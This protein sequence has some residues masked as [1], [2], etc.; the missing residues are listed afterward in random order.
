[1]IT[2]GWRISEVAGLEVQA[3][4]YSY[5]AHRVKNSQRFPKILSLSN[6]PSVACLCSSHRYDASGTSGS[7]P[8]SRRLA[9]T[10]SFR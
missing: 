6:A 3:A 5:V 10:L 4:E 8:S 9:D 1:M 2:L 7:E